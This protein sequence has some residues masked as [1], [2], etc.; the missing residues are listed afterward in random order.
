ME[1]ALE[2]GGPLQ[3]ALLALLLLDV[4]RVVSRERLIDGLWN[5]EPPPRAARS[6]ETK[7]SRLRATLGAHAS[8]VARG[9]GYVIDAPADELD[10]YRFEQALEEG[11]SL[12]AEDPAAARW[13]LQS[14]LALWRGEPL[15]GLPDGVLAV[16]R[17]R[18]E[19]KRLEALEARIDADLR[20]GEGVS[21]VGELEKLRCEY[22]AR[23]RVTEQLMLA[24][25]RS[26]RHTD[27]LEAY[28]GTYRYLRDELGLEPGPRL[29]E[30]EQA[31]LRHDASLGP[32]PMRARLAGDSRRL[33]LVG[34]AAT[35]CAVALAGILVAA[36]GGTHQRSVRSSPGLILVDAASGAVRADVPVG[37]SQGATRFGYGHVWTLGENGVMAEVDPDK[38]ALVRFIPVGVV[39]A[40]W[41][42]APAG[43]G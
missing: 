8:V 19:G 26:G 2:L 41:R 37:D 7:V 15:S 13:R 10:L 21:L 1:T 31:I 39:W 27:A 3:R 4:G 38:G 23:E 29:R 32:L 42:S 14:A 30:L 17:A 16:E 36:L 22:P 35:V 5:T 28:R 24:L 40:A 43:S 20:L 25:Y 6:L 33:R 34:V 9:G 12:L 11:R 18:L